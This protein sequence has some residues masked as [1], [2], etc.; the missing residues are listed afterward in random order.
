MTKSGATSF[1]ITIV[2]V[3]VV[4]SVLY[5]LYW[6]PYPERSGGG[7]PLE[8]IASESDGSVLYGQTISITIELFNT[9]PTSVFN[10][11]S[12]WPEINGKK[13]PL[14]ISPCS[15]DWPYGFDLFS[16]YVTNGTLASSKPLNLWQIGMYS[17]PV[18]FPVGSYKVNGSSDS[19]YILS[20]ENQPIPITL[21]SNI[22]ISGYW[23][24][25]ASANGTSYFIKLPVGQYTVLVADEWSEAIF[26]H[27]RVT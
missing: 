5:L 26:L 2:S 14:S 17:C 27:F 19:G 10:V 12:S 1:V 18:I 4:V 6:T 9:G 22:S 13:I 8:L 25:N 20:A 24:E 3:I 11:S 21:H 23:S 7:K 15:Y 16:G